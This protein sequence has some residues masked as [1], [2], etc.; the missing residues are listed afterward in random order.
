MCDICH[1]PSSRTL[2]PDCAAAIRR[3]IDVLRNG[4]QM[5]VLKEF[6]ASLVHIPPPEEA[7]DIKATGATTGQ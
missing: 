2:C 4:E 6:V 7:L 3:L 1:Q 5:G